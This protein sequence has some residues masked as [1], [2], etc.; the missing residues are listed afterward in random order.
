MVYT[1]PLL[2]VY[3]LLSGAGGIQAAAITKDDGTTPA[4]FGIQYYVDKPSWKSK[5]QL[6]EDLTTYNLLVSVA[7]AN[8]ESARP[9]QDVPLVWRSYVR[10]DLY[11]KNVVVG[12]VTTITARTLIFKAICEVRRVVGAN[13]FG[14]GYRQQ[15]FTEKDEPHLYDPTATLYKYSILIR[16]DDW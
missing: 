7:R 10:V 4:T 1:D 5:H 13:S 2:A 15:V 14:S 11:A 8:T 3:T 12:G 9:I 16:R 6:L